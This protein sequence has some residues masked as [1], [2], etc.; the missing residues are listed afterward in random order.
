MK[1]ITLTNPW[2]TLV[3][4]GAK[5]IETR[6]WKTSYRGPLAIHAAKGFPKEA[7]RF[8]LEPV[9]YEAI[10]KLGYHAR[11]WFQAYPTG[12]V[13]ATCR[14]IDC[15]PTEAVAVLYPELWSP[16]EQAFGNYDA[17]RWAWILGGVQCFE[18]PMPAKGAL[19][20]WEWCPPGGDDL[21]CVG[22]GRPIPQARGVAREFRY[23]TPECMYRYKAADF[24]PGGQEGA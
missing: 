15:V 19:S 9:V 13:I 16:Q 3:A 11:G 24:P 2:A 14:L 23:C 22:C 10:Q 18:Q 5:R 17:G 1:A 7:R 6:S 20:L 8:T 12:S 4:I 21:V